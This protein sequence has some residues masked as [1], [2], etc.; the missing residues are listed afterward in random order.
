MDITNLIEMDN[1]T[2]T[3]FLLVYCDTRQVFG[4]FFK[5]I[6]DAVF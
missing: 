5:K 6:M 3:S 1:L 4:Y 2:I